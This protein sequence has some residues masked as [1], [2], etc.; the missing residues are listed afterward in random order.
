MTGK[1]RKGTLPN[2]III[3]AQKCGTT[4]L[5]Y[6][7]GLHPQISMSREKE[8]DFFLKDRNWHRGIEWY[9]SRFIARAKVHGESSPN[10]TGYPMWDGVPER[11]HSVIP[12]AKLIYILRDPI[13]RM[14][15]HYIQLQSVGLE[16]R[17]VEVAFKPLNNDNGYICRSRYF[18]QLQQY[19][20]YFPSSNILII[21]AEDLLNERRRTLEKVFAFLGVDE[22]FYS[23]KFLSIKHGSVGKRRKN[24]IG[25]LLKQFAED[26]MTKIFS[27]HVRMKFGKVIGLAFATEI[28]RPVLDESFRA[29][30]ISFFKEDIDG[31]KEFTD[32]DF[33]LWSV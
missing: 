6:Y 9:Q 24:R 21:T 19:L 4:S 12:G 15:S 14:V 17:A 23:P 18:M 29:E 27:T 31:L 25:L 20:P 32:A 22:T 16:D 8:L 5:H 13:E 33:G 10:Y 30:L 7:L 1:Y 28:A 26:N 11:M 2:L 3:G